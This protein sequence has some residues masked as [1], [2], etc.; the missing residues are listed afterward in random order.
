[1][2]TQP[3]VLNALESQF[4]D[5]FEDASLCQ[6]LILMEATAQSLRLDI[7]LDS[8]L[9]N[10]DYTGARDKDVEGLQ[11][12]DFSDSTDFQDAK[13]GLL[14]MTFLGSGIVQDYSV[15]AAEERLGN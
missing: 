12:L 7:G 5:S 9:G 3:T 14:I 2:N 1:M 10:L 11:A 6:K 8:A 15:L 13:E 4:G